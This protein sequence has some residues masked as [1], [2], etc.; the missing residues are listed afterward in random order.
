MSYRY[1]SGKD[2][3]ATCD[4]CGFQYTLPDLRTVIRKGQ[5]T[6]IKACPTCWDKDHPQLKLGETP[7]YDPQ[8]VR[9]PR[10]DPSMEASRELTGEPYD[11]WVRNIR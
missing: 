4:V 5:D 2:S 3:L 6:N 11:V 8:A 1:A 10:P 9:N 7:V